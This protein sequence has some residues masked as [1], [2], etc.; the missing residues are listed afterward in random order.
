MKAY[1]GVVKTRM[2]RRHGCIWYR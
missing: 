2:L 1:T